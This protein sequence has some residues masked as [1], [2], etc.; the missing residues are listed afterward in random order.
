MIL[1]SKSAPGNYVLDIDENR[2]KLEVEKILELNAIKGHV[3]LIRVTIDKY[4][5]QLQ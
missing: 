1:L 2:L 4:K 5:K 3:I